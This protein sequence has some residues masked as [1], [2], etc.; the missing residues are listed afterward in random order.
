MPRYTLNIDGMKRSGAG[1][2]AIVCF[3]AAIANAVADATGVRIRRYPLVPD[4]AKRL[5]A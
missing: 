2:P 1:E 3:P 5:L 4:R